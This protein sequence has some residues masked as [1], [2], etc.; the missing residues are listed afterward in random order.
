MTDTEESHIIAKRIMKRI[1]NSACNELY[2]LLDNWDMES[3]ESILISLQ[4][5]ESLAQLARKA[6][7]SNG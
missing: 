3:I 4:Y 7:E 2:Y 1:A 6:A 5:V